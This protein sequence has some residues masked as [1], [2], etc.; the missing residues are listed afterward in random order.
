MHHERTNTYRKSRIFATHKNVAWYGGVELN[1]I[2]YNNISIQL[3]AVLSCLAIFSSSTINGEK[4]Q[5]H[6]FQQ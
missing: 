2:H 4:L 3:W 1:E 5:L 6:S